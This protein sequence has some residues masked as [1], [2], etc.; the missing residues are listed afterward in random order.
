M[1]ILEF[2]H[3]SNPKLL[4]IHGFQCPWQVWEPYI[5]HYQDTFHVLVPIL[6]GHDPES[7]EEFVSFAED[8]KAIEDDLISRYGNQLFAVYGMSMGGVLAATLWQN[9]RL[10]FERVVFD[11]SPLVSLNG[12]VKGFMQRFYLDITHKC[13]K[14]DSK[15]LRQATRVIIPEDKLEHLLR[16][17]DHMTDTTIVNSLNG[18][19]AFNLK[20]GMDTAGTKIFFLHGTA[21]NE[22]LARQSAKRLR[23]LYP[24]SVVKCFKGKFH[25]ENV[26]F[27][28]QV[29]IS[30]LDEVFR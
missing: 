29:M 14:R 25:C 30:E 21:L 24:A 15:T 16:V 4:L 3:S 22:M 8:A 20:G 11:G 6:S 23:K 1:K 26:L 17:L 27:H 10:S 18:I 9:G 12:F 19:A 28:P 13:Q 5:Q 2:G 7:D